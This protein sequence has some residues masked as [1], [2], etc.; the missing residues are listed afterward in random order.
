MTEWNQ[1][2]ARLLMRMAPLVTDGLA[3]DLADGLRKALPQATP[4]AAAIEF[5]S[6]MPPKWGQPTEVIV[7]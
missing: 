4:A 1:E 5:L 6:H 7:C 2:V 3:V